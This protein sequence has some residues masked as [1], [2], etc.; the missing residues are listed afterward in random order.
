MNHS[1]NTQTPVAVGRCEDVAIIRYPNSDGTVR[2]ILHLPNS[3]TWV[4]DSHASPHDHL[5]E[6]SKSLTDKIKNAGNRLIEA[7]ESN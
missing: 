7:L 1:E 3:V 5:T 2:Y 4:D 6:F